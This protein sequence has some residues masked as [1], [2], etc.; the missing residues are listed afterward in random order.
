MPSKVSLSTT[1]RRLRQLLRMAMGQEELGRL[2]ALAREEANLSQQELAEKIGLSQGQSI[3]NYE[4]AV[5]EVPARR[6]RSIAE[7]T[8]KPIGF[9]LGE[10]PQASP[11]ATQELLQVLGQVQDGVEEILRRLPASPE[12]DSRSG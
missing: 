5:T 4:R 1:P 2:I 6:L 12:A 9:F 3:S 11:E 8:G 7:V 10:Q